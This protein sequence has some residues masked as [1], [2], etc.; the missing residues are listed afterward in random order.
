MNR[1]QAYTTLN[2]PQSTLKK[3]IAAQLSAKLTIGTTTEHRK[4]DAQGGKRQKRLKQPD[5]PHSTRDIA[6]CKGESRPNSV[7]QQGQRDRERVCE[8][9]SIHPAQ[10]GNEP[11]RLKLLLAL[12]SIHS[13]FHKKKRTGGGKENDRNDDGGGGCSSQEEN[14][15]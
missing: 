13:I 8:R 6:R 2:K 12:A 10:G 15:K 5:K 14:E 9:E 7:E 3:G 1:V 11:T 4:R